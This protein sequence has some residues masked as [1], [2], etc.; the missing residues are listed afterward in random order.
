MSAAQ[1]IICSVKLS[2]PVCMQYKPDFMT[3]IKTRES[4]EL[5]KYEEYEVH[6]KYLQGTLH[7]ADEGN[8]FN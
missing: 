5:G 1:I 8:V 7:F 4:P 2:M 6:L 3:P